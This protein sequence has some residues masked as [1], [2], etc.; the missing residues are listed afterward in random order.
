VLPDGSVV[1]KTRT[2]AAALA[3]HREGVP[4]YAVASTDRV[5]TDETVPLEFGDRAAVYDGDAPVDVR[6]LRST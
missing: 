6:N 4:L 2:R 5:A 1:N 3:A